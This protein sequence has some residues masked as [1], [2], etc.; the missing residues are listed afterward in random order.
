MKPLVHGEILSGRPLGMPQQTQNQKSD[1]MMTINHK[2]T[3]TTSN[4]CTLA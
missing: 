1:G 4:I 2:Q 3:P